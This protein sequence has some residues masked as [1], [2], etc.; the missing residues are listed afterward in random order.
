MTYATVKMFHL[1]G[2]VLFLGNIIVTAFW[3][4]LADR[5]GDVAIIRFSQQLVNLT[6]MVFTAGGASLIVATGLWLVPS[7]DALLQQAWLFWS[8][9]AFGASAVIWLGLLVPI[10]WRQTQLLR[11][12]SPDGDIDG[13]YQRLTRWWTIFGM[14]A[15]IL[16]FLPLWLMVH[17]G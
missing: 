2:V 3:K 16:P 11:E 17:K 7:W 4:T 15:T 14:I 5:T 9:A 1:L 10:Q 13:R 6:D 12:M 8:L